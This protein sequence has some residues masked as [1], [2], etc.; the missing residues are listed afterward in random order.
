MATALDM[1]KRSMRLL[2]ALGQGEVP[3]AQE[4]TDGLNALN[5]MLDS[6]L[7]D[8]LM[9]Y[10]ILEETFTWTANASSKTIGS[11]GD[12]NTTRPT[13]IL[14]GFTRINSVDYPYE[15]IDQDQY[16]A[17]PYKTVTS[18]FPDKIYYDNAATLGTLYAYP[19]PNADVSL[20]LNSWKQLQSF[21]T[22]STALTLPPGYQ[23][24]IEF[25]LA[26][27]FAPELGLPV[28]ANVA[29]IANQAKAAIKRF[30]APQIVSGFDP[31][32]TG[33]GRSNIISGI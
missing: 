29:Q 18:S 25:N 9:V 20:H 3:T 21:T 22:L 33:G 26:V 1:I 31:A 32:V 5:T 4:A 7:V 14:P 2:G 15:V 8:R 30:N 11:G 17:L 16:D 6:W 10:Q 28:P 24:A 27:E 19:I 13:R 23:R 12:F